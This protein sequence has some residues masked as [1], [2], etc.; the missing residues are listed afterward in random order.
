MYYGQIFVKEIVNI[1]NKNLN[2][3]QRLITYKN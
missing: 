3:I 1:K 2:L